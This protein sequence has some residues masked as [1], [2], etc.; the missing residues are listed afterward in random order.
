MKGN[1]GPH[2]YKTR[3]R[4][5]LESSL[6]HVPDENESDSDAGNQITLPDEKKSDVAN[7][8]ITLPD[9]K[10]SDAANQI[11]TL[12]CVTSLYNILTCFLIRKFPSVVQEINCETCTFENNRRRYS[13]VLNK[14]QF[15]KEE[16]ALSIIK[17]VGTLGCAMCEQ[18]TASRNHW[19]VH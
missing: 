15:L 1:I 16:L 9:E 12:N 19:G 18:R 6:F 5:L 3:G 14:E 4:L 8:I 17:N 10:E 7:Q 2:T 11:I 13:I